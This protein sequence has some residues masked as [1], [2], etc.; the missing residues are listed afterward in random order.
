MSGCVLRVVQTKRA[1]KMVS[2][3]MYKSPEHPFRCFCC[4]FVSFFVGFF[5]DLLLL[6]LLFSF[7]SSSPFYL[8]L[9]LLP[10]RPRSC[11]V[12]LL[13]FFVAVFV[14]VVFCIVRL[15]IMTKPI[16]FSCSKIHCNHSQKEIS[17]RENV[18]KL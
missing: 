8:V 11:C 5:V 18:W 3:E 17:G 4:C 1:S 10:P 16:L 12:F 9:L 13:L 15:M 14:V 6:L 7:V 2:D